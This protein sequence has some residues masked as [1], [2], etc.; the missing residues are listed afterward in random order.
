MLCAFI[1]KN[2]LQNSRNGVRILTTMHAIQEYK[3]SS[4]KS[5]SAHWSD[6][7]DILQFVPLLAT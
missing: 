1:V 7:F 6:G 2:V 3:V 4:L 5:K